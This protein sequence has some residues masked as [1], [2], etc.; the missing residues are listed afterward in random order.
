LIKPTLATLVLVL[1]WSQ[2]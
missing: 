2:L 1:C